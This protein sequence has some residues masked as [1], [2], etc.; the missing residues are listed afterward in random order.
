MPLVNIGKLFDMARS[1]RPVERTPFGQRMFDARTAAGLSQPQVCKE[2]RISQGT[3]SEAERT[4]G[5]SSHAVRFAA[6]YR[7]RPEW[8][9]NGKGPMK[10]EAAEHSAERAWPFERITGAQWASMSERERGALEDAAVAKW[11]ELRAEREPLA[12]S[13]DTNVVSLPPQDATP[14]GYRLVKTAKQKLAHKKH[15]KG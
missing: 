7:V 15:V 2:L 12:P 3:L 6:L 10:T 13:A 9:A 5:G 11:R 14:E 4:A 1:S 8:L